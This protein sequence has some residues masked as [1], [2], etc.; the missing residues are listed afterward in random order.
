MVA[1]RKPSPSPATRKRVATQGQARR[2][3]TRPPAARTRAQP[4]RSPYTVSART[5]SHCG[6]RGVRWWIRG[7][8]GVLHAYAPRQRYGVCGGDASTPTPRQSL[9]GSPRQMYGHAC[10]QGRDGVKLAPNSVY[11]A[12]SNKYLSV[13]HATLHQLEAAPGEACSS[14]STSFSVPWRTTSRTG[15]LVSCC[16]VRNGR[17]PG[18]KSDQGRRRNNHGAECAVGQVRRDAPQRPGHG[19]RRLCVTTIR[20]AGAVVAYVQGSYLQDASQNRT[21]CPTC[22]RRSFFSCE[23]VPVTISPAIKRTPSLGVLHDG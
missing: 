16:L 5:L 9:A 15:P 1:R 18:R 12:P 13:L 7:A 22:Y 21:H 6:D 14:P 23:T 10:A 8:R 2:S 19:S 17:H 20:H 3:A 4:A 11:I